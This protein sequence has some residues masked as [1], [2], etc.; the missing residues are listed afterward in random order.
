[1]YTVK[2]QLKFII[3]ILGILF[4]SVSCNPTHEPKKDTLYHT[5]LSVG[6]QLLMVNLRQT[7]SE[8]AKGL[9]GSLPISDQQGMLFDFTQNPGLKTFWMKEMLFGLDLIWIKENKIVGITPQIPP[10]KKNTPESE[11]ILYPSPEVVDMVLEVNA[12]WSEENNIKL[13]EKIKIVK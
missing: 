13:G 3:L 1:M 10:P 4:L 2:L 5:P 8:Q 9:S 6:K 11:L 12:G 7:P